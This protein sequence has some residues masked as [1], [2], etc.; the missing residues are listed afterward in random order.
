MFQQDPGSY[1]PRD[2]FTKAASQRWGFGTEKRLRAGAQS[3]APGAGTYSIPS[4]VVEGPSFPIGM[5]L[6]DRSASSLLNSPGPGQY[7]L[8]NKDNINMK[9]PLKFGMG[10]SKRPAVVARSIATVPAPGAY[11]SSMA[12]KSRNPAF[13][14]GS[15]KRGHGGKSLASI[16]G[17]GT[18][19]LRGLTGQEGRSSS[20][21]G[22]LQYKPIDKSGGLTPG[23]GAY[24]AHTKNKA[25]DPAWGTGTS[26]RSGDVN[27]HILANP[28]PGAHSPTTNYV[29]R[30]DPKFGFGS[31]QRKGP[32]DGKK[33]VSPGPGNY[34]IEPLAFSTK[35]AQFYM[36]QKLPQ[37]KATTAVPGAGAYNPTPEKTMQTL[38]LYSMKIKLASGLGRDNKVPGP[39]TYNSNLNDK[40][41]PARY[42][43][44]TS[45]REHASPKRAN[46]SP[47]PGAYKINSTV[48]DVPSY[49]MPNRP[50]AYKYV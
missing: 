35:R 25:K 16:P 45:T 19:A 46:L 26:K 12:D 39:G 8:Q 27:K 11:E 3:V 17:P 9:L 31:E 49:A 43:F 21:H 22:K 6:N 36:G 28:G 7:D 14:F 4:R 33:S 50:D 15:G 18:Y 42:G 13:G 41:A 2:G 24:E 32:A 44:G 1:D 38:P 5:K 34:N 40:R 29:L 23:P 48:G 30:A 47:G 37:V 10:T 20:I